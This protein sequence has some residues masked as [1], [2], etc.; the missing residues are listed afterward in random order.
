VKGVHRKDKEAADLLNLK[1]GEYCY[2]PGDGWYAC[3]P[4][5]HLAN[6]SQ[7]DCTYDK[8]SDTLT[9]AP[10]ILCGD[11]LPPHTAKR[12]AAYEAKA[13]AEGRAYHGYLEAGVWRAC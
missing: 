9:V 12:D 13:I 1:P 3:T 10:S 7:H 6:L 2:R 8:E 11:F 4:N 5:G